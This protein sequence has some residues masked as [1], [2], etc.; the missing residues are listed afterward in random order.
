MKETIGSGV[1]LT[2]AVDRREVGL[3]SSGSSRRHAESR[4]QECEGEQEPKRPVQPPPVGMAHPIAEFGAK[5]GTPPES[6][7]G[8]RERRTIVQ[9]NSQPSEST[10]L[11]AA[12]IPGT[13]SECDAVH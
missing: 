4:E 11:N 3:R 2:A 10:E 9:A 1:L 5:P 13:P 6:L 7:G 12:A 8:R